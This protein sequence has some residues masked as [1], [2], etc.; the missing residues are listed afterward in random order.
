MEILF[1]KNRKETVFEGFCYYNA[2]N[3]AM[4]F[5]KN[6]ILL[7]VYK[8]NCT[9]R[10]YLPKKVFYKLQDL[11]I[12]NIVKLY[13]Y[14][15][16]DS[17]KIG[18][19]FPMEAYTMEYVN[20]DKLNIIYQNKEYLLKTIYLLEKAIYKL[21]INKV[22]VN[23]AHHSNIIFNKEGATLIDVDLYTINNLISFKKILLYNQEKI[24]YF[25]RSKII[26]ELEKENYNIKKFEIN[27]LFNIDLRHKSLSEEI[28]DMFTEDNL[29]NSI[30]RKC[31]K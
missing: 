29:I 28:D 7:K 26:N 13:D 31:Y 22:G 25:I 20:N 11:D 19:I 5:K 1:D 3:C 14:Y 16:F 17:S 18:R 30:K 15:Y 27:N 10:Y 9:Y 8:S 12:S 6:N 21:S 2:G 4:I 24:L 23:D